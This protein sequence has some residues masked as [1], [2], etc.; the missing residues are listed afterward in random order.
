[1]SALFLGF[2][3]G[4]IAW[5]ATTVIGEP[6]R[7]FIPLRHEATV[8]IIRYEECAWIGDP[9]ASPPD[10]EW[11]EKRREAYDAAGIALMAFATSNTLFSRLLRSPYLGKLRCYP[12]S[13]GSDLRELGSAYP[14]MQASDHLQRSALRA[15][16]I[17]SGPHLAG[18]PGKIILFL[19]IASWASAE[20]AGWILVNSRHYRSRS[21]GA[22]MLSA[23]LITP[24]FVAILSAI[25]SIGLVAYG[26]AFGAPSLSMV[27]VFPTFRQYWRAILGGILLAATAL[28]MIIMSAYGRW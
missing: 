4:V 20:V 2:I 1:M 11:L 23:L 13:G 21:A 14:G 28:A 15:L 24:S 5:I 27:R 22:D 3:G 10:N 9:E 7:R 16:K 18:K 12:Y 26:A 17:K 8:V 19:G 6:L 25:L